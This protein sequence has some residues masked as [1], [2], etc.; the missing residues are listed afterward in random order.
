MHL[1]RHMAPGAALVVRSTHG[2]RGFLYPVVDPKE[3]R[4]GGF[5]VLVVH[6]R[7]FGWT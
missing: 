6:S 2:V 5:D 4:H 1:G 7:A 3:I